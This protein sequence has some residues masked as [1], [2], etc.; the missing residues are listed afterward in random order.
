ALNVS[1][2]EIAKHMLVNEF[3]VKTEKIDREEDI[4]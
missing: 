4:S 1:C 2:S 3:A